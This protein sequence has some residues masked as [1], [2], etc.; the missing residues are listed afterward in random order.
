DLL[1]NTQVVVQEGNQIQAQA[2]ISSEKIKSKRS[3]EPKKLAI[4]HGEPLQYSEDAPK[5][6]AELLQRTAHNSTKGIVYIQS[7]ATEKNQSYRELW[8]D[9]QRISG[10]LR[11]LGLKPQDKVILQLDDNQDFISAFWGCVLGGFVS[12]PVSIAP[13]YD[14]VNS[15]TSKLQNVWQMLG[16]PLVLAGASLAPKIRGLSSLLNLENFQVETIDK[17]RDCEPDF[18]WHSSEPEDLAVLLLTSG[19]TGVPKAVM[20]SHGSLIGR[21]AGTTAMNGFTSSDVSLNWLPLDHVGGIIM[22]HVRD[23]Y[24]SCEQIHAPTELVLQQPTRWLDWISHY[25]TTITWAPNFAYGLINEQLE[26]LKKQAT[27]RWDLSKMR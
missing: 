2:R 18:N 3:V 8:H 25:Q 4:S 1:S 13:T 15:I 14:Q 16:K 12:V 9:A 11:K 26:T 6:L 23:V 24:L 7:D 22:F 20:Q 5:T 17:L 10:G 19:S 27:P 21:C